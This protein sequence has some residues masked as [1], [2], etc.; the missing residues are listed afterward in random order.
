MN[1]YQRQELSN[2]VDYLQDIL[3]NPDEYEKWSDDVSGYAVDVET[4]ADEEQAKYDNLPEN[5][6]WSSRADEYQDNVSELQ[7]AQ[8]AL[9]SA[10]ECDSIED[11]E[12]DINEAISHIEN[13]I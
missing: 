11:A 13:L 8:Y 3:N 10:A 4:M 2:I 9:E 12:D 5:L 6:Q 7:D 1:K